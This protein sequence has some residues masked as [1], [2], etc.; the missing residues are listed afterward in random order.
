M[1]KHTGFSLIE[2]ITAVAVVAIL[3]GIAIPSFSALVADNRMDSWS[4]SLSTTLKS[5]RVEAITRR[6]EI[7]VCVRAGDACAATSTTNWEN[8]WLTMTTTGDL[9]QKQSALSGV[10]FNSTLQAAPG[11]I[12]FTPRGLVKNRNSGDLE[13]CDVNR[14]GETGNR[15]TLQVSGRTTGETFA[16]L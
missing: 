9:L 5:A 15:I 7:M 14:A 2:M 3:A 11:E 6:Q 8:G 13:I 1:K 4:G 10:S 16:C 12:V